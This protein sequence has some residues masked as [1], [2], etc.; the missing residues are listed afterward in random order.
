MGGRRCL[1]ALS[2]HMAGGSGKERDDFTHCSMNSDHDRLCEDEEETGRAVQSSMRKKCKPKASEWGWLSYG[3][4]FSMEEKNN[5]CRNIPAKAIG[6]PENARRKPGVLT[7]S[8]SLTDVH[9][10]QVTK[11]GFSQRQL[12]LQNLGTGPPKSSVHG[13]QARVLEWLRGKSVSQGS[14]RSL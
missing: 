1:L 3:E 13:I 14:G 8:V 5:C 9:V 6:A 12:L 4:Q 7:E 11:S 2:R 10:R